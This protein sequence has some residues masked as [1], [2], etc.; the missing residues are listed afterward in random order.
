ME[1]YSFHLSSYFEDCSGGVEFP[2]CEFIFQKSTCFSFTQV[3]FLLENTN[4]P[5]VFNLRFTD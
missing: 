3:T 1:Q 5:K 2:N 4:I